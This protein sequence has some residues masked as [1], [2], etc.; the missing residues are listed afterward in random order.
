MSGR[1]RVVV[2]AVAVW[3]VAVTGTTTLAWVVIDRAGRSIGSTPTPLA[4]DLGPPRAARSPSEP[5]A[6]TA[7]SATASGTPSGQPPGRPSASA[8]RSASPPPSAA[9]LTATGSARA[10][11]TTTSPTRQPTSR[12]AGQPTTRT[13]PPT[14]PAGVQRVAHVQGGVVAVRCTAVSIA[15][16]WA[17]PDD[18]WSVETAS[19]GSAELEVTFRS[20]AGG[21]ERETQV[22]AVCQ[23]SEPVLAVETQSSSGD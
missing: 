14:A 22:H 5:G 19:S 10:P 18:G 6:S 21:V 8:S 3:L 20:S 12:P 16:R 15:L 17:Q 1:A 2:L 13:P 23:R 11:T 7:R 9:R 4:A